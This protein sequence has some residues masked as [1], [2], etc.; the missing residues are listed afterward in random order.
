[1]ITL[2]HQIPIQGNDKQGLWR[3]AE[4]PLFISNCLQT[5][6]QGIRI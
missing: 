1:M 6:V 4:Y 5:F 2:Y 3:I